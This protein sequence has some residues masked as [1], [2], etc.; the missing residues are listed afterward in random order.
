MSVRREIRWMLYIGLSVLKIEPNTD[1]DESIKAMLK[2]CS[3][4][5]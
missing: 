2:S 3:S 4:C 5:L 1:E